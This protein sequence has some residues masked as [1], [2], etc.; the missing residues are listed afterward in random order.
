MIEQKTQ[1]LAEASGKLAER[2]YA[3]QGAATGGAQTGGEEQPSTSKAGSEDVVD[4]EFEEV[5]DK[6]R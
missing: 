4:A 3:Q 6:K 5:D 2:I 1:T